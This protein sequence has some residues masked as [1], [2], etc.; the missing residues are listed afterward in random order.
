MKQYTPSNMEFLNTLISTSHAQIACHVSYSYL[1]NLSGQLKII[2]IHLSFPVF[3][4][5]V[6]VGQEPLLL[7]PKL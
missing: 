2:V 7:K 4:V 3:R 5:Q 6:S 1:R